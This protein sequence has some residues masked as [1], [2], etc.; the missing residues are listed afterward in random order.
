MTRGRR[1]DPWLAVALGVSALLVA[2]VAVPQLWLVGA[3]LSAADGSFT[4]A[5]FAEFFG[6]GRYLAALRNSVAVSVIVCLLALAIAVPLAFVHARYALPGR[7]AVLTL[8]AMA[9]ITPPFLGAYVWIM[10]LGWSGILSTALRAAGI[11]FDSIVG[12]SGIVWVGTWSAVGLVFMFAYDAFSTMDPS[13][14]EAA[15][16]VGASRLRAYLRVSLPMATPALL[17]VAYL[18][19]MAAFTDFGTPRIIGGEVEVLPV[20]VYDAFMGEVATRPS[21]A[22]TASLVMVA[23][24]TLV[25][26]VQRWALTRRSYALSG[27]ARAHPRPLSRTGSVIVMAWTATVFLIVFTPHLVVTALSFFTWTMDVP[28]LPATLANYESLGRR[29]LT[30][31]LVSYGLALAS[32][33]AA[34]LVGVVAAYVVARKGFAILGPGL[35]ALVMLPYLIPGTVLAVGLIVAFSRPP[36]ALTGTGLILGIA[37]FIR[38]LPYAMKAAEAALYQVHPSMEEAAMSV[39]AAPARAFRD[40]TARLILPGLASGATVTFLA[41]ITELSATIM[42]Y[43]AAWTTMTVVI[44]QAAQGMGGQFG[45]ASATAVVMMASIYVPLYLVRRHYRVGAVLT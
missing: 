36:L 39:G 15:M 26:M 3:S 10:L 13:L 20:L 42:L 45:V 28:H 35:N 31:V 30:P 4:L 25:L 11:P 40:V 2:L 19:L 32:T 27:S 1:R 37:Y 8:A 43:S 16:S 23:L 9:T 14:E 44:F 29:S 6:G 34:V 21:M 38:K 18:V 41:T 17:T 12:L 33:F 24:S 7:G 5:H 22:S